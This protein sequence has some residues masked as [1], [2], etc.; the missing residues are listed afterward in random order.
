MSNEI[1]TWIFYI[2]V[3]VAMVL[4][5]FMWHKR[6]RFLRAAKER[7]LTNLNRSS[8]VENFEIMLLTVIPTKLR[9]VSG[10]QFEE[11]RKSA[12][13]AT[14]YWIVSLMLM[15]LLPILLFNLFK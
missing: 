11:L 2:L 3:M 1:A 6:S 4:Q 10:G 14:N 15:L 5:V 9:A 13:K 7:Q 12:V 8:R